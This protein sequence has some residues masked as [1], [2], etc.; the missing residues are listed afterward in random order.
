MIRRPVICTHPAKGGLR[1]QKRADHIDIEH[2]AKALYR[3]ILDRHAFHAHSRVVEKQIEAT[4]AFLHRVEE[5]LYRCRVG[6]IGGNGHQLAG[7]FGNVLLV[8]SNDRVER[9]L[10][11]SGERD[12]PAI[13]RERVHR[14]PTNTAACSRDDGYAQCLLCVVSSHDG[15]C[16][17]SSAV[18]PE[19]LIRHG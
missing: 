11:T 15:F 9:L 2:R 5:T 14:C 4:V 17:F 16:L 1:A 6:D 3:K 7:G 10:P 8:V 19:R 18:G 12:T 13:V